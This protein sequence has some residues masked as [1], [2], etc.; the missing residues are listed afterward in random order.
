MFAKGLRQSFEYVFVRKNGERFPVLLNSEP[1]IKNDKIVG[2]RGIVVDITERKDMEKRLQEQERLA[3]IGTTAGMVGHD[4][5]NPLQA[6]TGDVYLARA[7]LVHTPQSKERKN[8][9]ENLQEIEKSIDYIN[10]IVADLQDF[11]RAICPVGKETD[12][13]RLFKEILLKS[14]LPDSIKVFCKVDKGAKR[15]FVDP[16]LLKRVLSNLVLN[17]VQAMPEGGELSVSAFI[18]DE[19][20][21]IEVK[22]TGVGIPEDVKAKIFTPMFTTKSKG[23]GLGLAVVKRLTE[24]MNGSVAFE[25]EQGKGTKFIVRLPNKEPKR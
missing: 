25:S 3:A 24:A 6:M 10:K 5:R 23:Q 8:A 2:A 20:F 16:E 13:V 4:I 11:A 17:A 18:K 1:I 22:D 9:L 12:L 14:N 19:C 15:A 7:E 21:V